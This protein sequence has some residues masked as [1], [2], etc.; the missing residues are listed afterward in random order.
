MWP[1]GDREL[2]IDL[3]AALTGARVTHAF[4]IPGGVRN[5]I[6]DGF[7]EKCLKYVSYYEKRL[8]EY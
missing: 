6:P 4:N 5:D 7:K 8:K 3:L 1:A 2:F